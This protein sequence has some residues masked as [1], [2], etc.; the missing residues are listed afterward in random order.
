M[1]TPATVLTREEGRGK[2]KRMAKERTM[3]ENAQT[4]NAQTGSE[5]LSDFFRYVRKE[6]MLLSP[7]H[8]RRWSDGVLRTLGT[9][10]D[11]GTKKR[12][13]KAI[14]EELADSLT[15]VFWLIHFRDPN[16]RSQDFQ[17]MAA[18]RSGNTDADFARIPTL[19]VFG[20]LKQMIDADLERAV[21]DA[22]APEIRELWQQA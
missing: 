8:A 6:G 13:A 21:A 19:A 14:P 20:G 4:G 22:L 2:K 15:G 12:L 7:E 3:T 5:T 1:E 16:L 17:R 9:A 11:R 18:R 10:L